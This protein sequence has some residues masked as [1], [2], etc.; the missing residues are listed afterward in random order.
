MTQKNIDSLTM[1]QYKILCE[2]FFK[3]PLD[4]EINITNKIG[5]L[6]S[7]DFK[8][9]FDDISINYDELCFGEILNWLGMR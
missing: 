8:Q 1:S 3:F 7:R 5:T 4:S 2:G 6:S 9:W